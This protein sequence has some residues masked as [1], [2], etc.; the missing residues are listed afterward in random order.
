MEACSLC[1]TSTHSFSSSH[2]SPFH[3]FTHTYTHTHTHTHAR[4]QTNKHFT[5]TDTHQ[6]T[7]THTPHM[8]RHTHKHIWDAISPFLCRPK[9]DQESQL[10]AFMKPS[11][12]LRE[13]QKRGGGV[14]VCVCVCGGEGEARCA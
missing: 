8:N 12:K 14:C 4:A 5:S 6:H 3:C 2:L 9:Q 10:Y 13:C 7:H 11:K 1:H